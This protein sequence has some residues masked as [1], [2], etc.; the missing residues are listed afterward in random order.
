MPSRITVALD[1]TELATILNALNLH[2][3][4]LA[5]EQTYSE[6]PDIYLELARKLLG[7]RFRTANEI[8]FEELRP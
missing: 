4:R 7:A 6:C 5:R 2:A 3:L 8:P 1:N